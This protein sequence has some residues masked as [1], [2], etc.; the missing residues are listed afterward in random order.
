MKTYTIT[1]NGNSYEVVVEEGKSTGESPAVK[2]VTQVSAPPKQVST[3]NVGAVKVNAP[4]PG[5]ILSV[6][7]SVGQTVKK[8]DV[9]VVLEAMKMEN[10]IVA[11]NDGTIATVSC[12]VGDQVEA[13]ALLISLN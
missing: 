1:V 7:A 5:K 2:K 11:P 3:G 6:K 13:G 8:G 9:I 10:D 12:A 4:M